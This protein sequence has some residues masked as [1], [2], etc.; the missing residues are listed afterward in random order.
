[1]VQRNLSI[2]QISMATAGIIKSK[3]HTVEPLN[4]DTLGQNS[5]PCKE[6]YFKGL[7]RPE[8]DE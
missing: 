2:L 1:M 5:V 7:I 4:N 6:V 3:M 8:D